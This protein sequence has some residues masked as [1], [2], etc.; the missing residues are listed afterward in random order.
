VIRFLSVEVG[1]GGLG[2]GVG[3]GFGLGDLTRCEE[4]A[5]GGGS[6]SKQLH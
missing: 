1:L 4:R 3:F 5:F 2:I 6:P